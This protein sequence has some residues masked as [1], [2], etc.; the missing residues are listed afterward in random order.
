MRK[1]HQALILFATGRL[2]GLGLIVIFDFFP[3]GRRAL[4]GARDKAHCPVKSYAA[5]WG[6][7]AGGSFTAFAHE[8]RPLGR[9]RRQKSPILIC[10][11]SAW[12]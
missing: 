1:P 5:C 6:A 10:L 4:R 8:Y 9:I 2:A 12:R 3:V 7:R 11:D